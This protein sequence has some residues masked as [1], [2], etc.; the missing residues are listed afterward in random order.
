MLDHWVALGATRYLSRSA[1][2][3]YLDEAQFAAAGITLEYLTFEHPR[4]PQIHNEFTPY[5]SVVDLVANVGAAA[6][7]LLS[8]SG[9]PMVAPAIGSPRPMTP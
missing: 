4:Y 9:H 1:G 8:G 3:S 2:R 7:D 5:L 6:G